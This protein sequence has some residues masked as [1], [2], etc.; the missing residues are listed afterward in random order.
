MKLNHWEQM[1]WA[2]KG[3]N[4]ALSSMMKELFLKDR[5]DGF[6]LDPIE[7]NGEAIDLI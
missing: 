5:E 4:P 2:F 7:D 1:C 6:E 3:E